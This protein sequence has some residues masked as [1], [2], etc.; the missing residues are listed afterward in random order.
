MAAGWCRTTASNPVPSAK[1]NYPPAQSTARSLRVRT[2]GATAWWT[3]F[4]SVSSFLRRYPG[5]GECPVD[6]LLLQQINS[7]AASL[8]HFLEPRF[9]VS[10][11]HTS[12]DGESARGSLILSF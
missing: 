6:F 3:G 9:P 10:A 4:R 12:P 2:F 8:A 11:A 1:Q 5:A 7:A